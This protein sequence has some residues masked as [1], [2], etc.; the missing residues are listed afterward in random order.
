MLSSKGIPGMSKGLL[1]SSYEGLKGF[2]G[3]RGS[4]IRNGFPGSSSML[5]T[6]G[7]SYE[8]LV[9]R[10]HPKSFFRQFLNFLHAL[11][12]IL[13]QYLFLLFSSDEGREGFKGPRDSSESL[14][15]LR[16][17]PKSFFRQF[18]K[19][20]RDLFFRFSSSA[21]LFLFFLESQ[22]NSLRLGSGSG[23]FPA[24]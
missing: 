21:P 8:P 12:L 24:P 17:H 5:S 7:K 13:G 22:T 2:K 10:Q 14:G 18:L 19:G 15:L 11:F 20:H 6:K 16:Q 23:F 1:F 3:S 4:R 9:F